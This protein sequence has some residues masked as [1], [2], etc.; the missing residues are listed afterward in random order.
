MLFL[1]TTL[2]LASQATQPT[3]NNNN[4]NNNTTMKLSTPFLTVLALVPSTVFGF[5]Y[6]G[7]SMFRPSVVVTPGIVARQKLIA[8]KRA[9]FGLSCPRYEL[10][11]NDEKFQVAMD[12]PGVSMKDITVNLEEDGKLLTI[13]GE[14]K[15]SNERY[16]FNSK[17]SQTFTIDPAVDVD[18]FTA[19]LKNGVL[20]VAAPKDMKRIETN[21]RQIPIM[22]MDDADDA[23]TEDT[24]DET[25]TAEQ[26][27]VV[28]VQSDETSKADDQ[29]EEDEA[30]E[31][32]D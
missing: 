15:S 8:R 32:E 2:E 30:S 25:A 20:I 14:R 29:P 10:T 7:R 19:N 5:G 26:D 11:D 3:N 1:L 28:N 27:T 4:N 16:Q 12:V 24:S 17:F 6:Y 13:S 9:S 18:K 31:K 21:I 23:A 22:T